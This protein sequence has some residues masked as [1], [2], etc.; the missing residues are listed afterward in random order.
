M[1][2]ALAAPTPQPWCKH[3]GKVCDNTRRDAE[4]DSEALCFSESGPC[5]MAKRSADALAEA[6]ENTINMF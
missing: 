3:V 5:S 1:A 2:D 4:A 6:A